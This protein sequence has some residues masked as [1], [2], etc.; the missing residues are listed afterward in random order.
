MVMLCVVCWRGDVEEWR[1]GSEVNLALRR[2]RAE[3]DA[4]A[5]V[6]QQLLILGLPR[7]KSHTRP[8]REKNI[9][10]NNRSVEV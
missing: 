5:A 7:V 9:M 8:L 6:Q 1:R 2:E 3:E 4:V 10:R